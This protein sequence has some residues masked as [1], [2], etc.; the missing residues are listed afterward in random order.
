[1][2]IHKIVSH[3]LLGMG[4]PAYRSGGS[5][6]FLFLFLFFFGGGGGGWGLHHDSR[7]GGGVRGMFIIRLF[8]YY[9][10]IYVKCVRYIL[11]IVLD[12]FTI[13]NDI[14][15]RPRWSKKRSM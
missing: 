9:K 11:F 14:C 12:S 13:V 3:H 7:G 6:Y 10:G 15:Q 4:K 8:Y 5:G 2:T 1:M